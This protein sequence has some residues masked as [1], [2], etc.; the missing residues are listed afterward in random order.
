MEIKTEW[1]EAADELAMRLTH[2]DGRSPR[3]VRRELLRAGYDFAEWQIQRRV[4]AVPGW[5]LEERA[6]RQA[7]ESKDPEELLEELLR[8]PL[9]ADR[10]SLDR[11]AGILG[12][13]MR[14]NKGDPDVIVKCARALADVTRTAADA[15]MGG[16]E[17]RLPR[18]ILDELEDMTE[19]ELSSLAS[20]RGRG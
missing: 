7:E 3:E 6:R 16:E 15:P 18:A 10:A 13:T 5:I 1:T 17:R 14:K 9:R 20:G 4:A 19:E 2:L 11:T 12:L 8:S